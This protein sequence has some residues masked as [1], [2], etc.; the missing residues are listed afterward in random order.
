MG[1]GVNIFGKFK[2][3]GEQ[4]KR[5]NE[6]KYLMDG[7]SAYYGTE[8]DRI[9]GADGSI[10]YQHDPFDALSDDDR[11][12]D[13]WMAKIGA[14]YQLFADLYTKVYYEYYRADLRDGTTAFYPPVGSGWWSAPYQTGIHQK[15]KFAIHLDYFLAGLEFGA[16]VQWFWG[17]YHPRFY[18]DHVFTLDA[19]G[20]A[21]VTT[22]DGVFVSSTDRTFTQY[23]LKAWMKVKF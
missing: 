9:I 5:V 20:R 7:G 4:D 11:D 19:E 16:D 8:P 15:N 23:R 13:Y 17:E 2:F 22:G 12:L 3:V 14:G 18:G 1:E 10:G 6:E 21:G